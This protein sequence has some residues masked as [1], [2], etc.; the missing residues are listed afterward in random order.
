MTDQPVYIVSGLPRSG[1]SMMMKMMEAGGIPVLTDNIR[2]ADIDNP[3][4]YYE[5]EKVKKISED[6]SWLAT[7]G[8]KVF[9][10][11]SMLLLQLPTDYSYKIVFMERDLN[12]V[13]RSEK[14]MLERLGKPK[15]ESDEEM[16][17]IFTLHLNHVKKWI[18]SQ[19]NI[20]VCY[21]N[22]NDMLGNPETLVEPLPAF[23][24]I[25]LNTNAMLEVV[26]PAL[27]RNRT[28]QQES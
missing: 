2:K 21:I 23:L 24:E 1:T 22:Y 8:G 6:S 10:M 17:R 25:D 19:S 7:A 12:E 20:D 27:Y 11:V 28:R 18:S 5:L 4:G 14:K 15:G 16:L 26:D 3:K 13:L 9:K